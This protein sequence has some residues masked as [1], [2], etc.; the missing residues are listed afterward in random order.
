MRLCQAVLPAMRARNHGQIVNIGSMVG[1]IPLP[2]MTGYAAAKSGLKGYSDALRRELCNTAITVTHIA[3]R[4]V[5]TGMNSGKIGMLNRKTKATEDRPRDVAL[6]IASAI[7]LNASDF[8]LGWPERLF[9]TL[10]ALVP[11]MIDKGLR[12]NTQIGE[13]ILATDKANAK[14]ALIIDGTGTESDAQ[15]NIA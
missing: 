9:A 8:R 10:N 5:N 6:R 3:P 12:K 15:R 13:E 7:E 14:P 2:H 11:A 1:L 4:A